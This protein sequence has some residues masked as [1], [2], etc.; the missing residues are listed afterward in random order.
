MDEQIQRIKDKLH[1][2]KCFDKDF[3]QYK[4]EEHKYLMNDC[5]N[6][7]DLNNFEQQYNIKLPDQ[8]KKFITNIGNGGCGP[9]GG[10]YPLQKFSFIVKPQIVASDSIVFQ[11]KWKEAYKNG[12]I[13]CLDILMRGFIPIGNQQGGNIFTLLCI[14]GEYI[15]KVF[16][17]DW[18]RELP[19]FMCFENSFLDWYERWL[20]EVIKGY[21]TTWFAWER[22]GDDIY[23]MGL[24]HSNESE[25]IKKESLRGMFKLKKLSN[26]TLKEIEKICDSEDLNL[27]SLSLNLLTKFDYS[28]AINYL[29]KNLYSKN[30]DKI[31][32]A[33]DCINKYA[34]N[35]IEEWGLLI[36]EN[37]KYM[38]DI[39]TFQNAILSLVKCN[40]DY[41][42]Y[43]KEF[44]GNNNSSVRVLCYYYMGKLSNRESYID[45][46]IDGLKDTSYL[47]NRE[48]I[49]ASIGIN[50]HDLLNYYRLLLPKREKIGHILDKAIGNVSD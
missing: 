29:K 47:V 24:Y 10:L 49:K 41:W 38:T 22:G 5:L 17:F 8:Y 36:S 44:A 3:K 50:N 42:I 7:S 23:L 34:K 35:H 40:A 27:F 15:N 20:D 21:D 30:N 46:I 25:D 4:A 48:A 14:N 19:F 28:L 13:N 37:L 1:L 9:F 33:L 16:Y 39:K 31:N 45:A 12:G 11:K 18:D 26:E 32:I 6:D 43:V 2:A